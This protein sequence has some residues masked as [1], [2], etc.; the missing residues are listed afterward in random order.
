MDPP[1]V[2]PGS[3][4]NAIARRLLVVSEDFLNAPPNSALRSAAAGARVAAKSSAT[5]SGPVAAPSPAV[6]STEMRALDSSATGAIIGAS[7]GAGA[8]A[9]D[10]DTPTRRLPAHCVSCSA[11]SM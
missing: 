8:A 6:L 3:S 10:V 7:A 4:L 5:A 1:S 9:F 2:E 11:S